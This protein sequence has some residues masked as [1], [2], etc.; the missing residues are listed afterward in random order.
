MYSEKWIYLVVGEIHV[1]E[2]IGDLR[3]SLVA[4]DSEAAAH[5]YISSRL[6]NKEGHLCHSNYLTK[7]TPYD[8]YFIKKIAL[9]Y[10]DD[11]RVVAREWLS[12]TP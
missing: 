4:F 3:Y 11:S 12:P 9:V 5:D 10:D 8:K 1:G 6:R 7:P 2:T